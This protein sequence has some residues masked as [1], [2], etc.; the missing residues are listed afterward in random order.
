MGMTI[1]GLDDLQKKL[2]RMA[3]ETP[4]AG[5]KFLAQEGELLRGR[6]VENTPVDTGRLRN[7]WKIKQPEPLR[8]EVYNNTEYAPF[9]EYGHRVKVHGK[10][11]GKVVPGQRML[12]KGLAET[13]DNFLEDAKEVLGA[14]LK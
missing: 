5:A 7:S 2:E 3:R 1:N 11:T 9:V 13:K 8:V 10:F 6:T 4:A 12:H 14:I